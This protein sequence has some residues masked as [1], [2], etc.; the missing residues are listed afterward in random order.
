MVTA[1]DMQDAL[2]LSTLIAAAGSILLALED[3]HNRAEYADTGLMS[4]PVAQLQWQW[5]DNQRIITMWRILYGHR[6][7]E[8]LIMARLV[9]SFVLVFSSLF[10]GEL[11]NGLLA[12]CI[13]LMLST[14]HMRSPYGGDGAD[15]MVLVVFV[16]VTLAWLLP[17]GGIAQRAALWFVALQ[18][19]LS[20][21]VAGLGKMVSTEWWNGTGLIGVLSTYSYGS[22]RVSVLAHRHP[23]LIMAM[24]WLVIL[25]EVGWSSVLLM[26]TQVAGVLFFIGVLFHLGTAVVMSLNTFTFAFVAAYPIA[27]YCVSGS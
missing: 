6:T 14:T 4:W 15:Q 10:L 26:P 7:L 9:L 22:P 17:D 1:M 19:I 3:W 11:L 12:A 27:W 16:G 8:L 5:S 25:F 23:S 21:T 13:L 18:L 24:S 20:Y 2:R